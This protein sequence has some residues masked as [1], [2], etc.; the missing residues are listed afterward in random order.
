MDLTHLKVSLLAPDLAGGGGTRVYLLS[1]VL[2]QL[3]CQVQ[4]CGFSFGDRLYPEPPADL[5]VAWVRGCNYPQIWRSLR[6]LWPH[7]QGDVLYAV[8]PR[9][10]SFGVGLLKRWR[11]RRPLLLDIDDWEMSWF[12]G[13]TWRYRPGPKQLARDLLKPQGALRNPQHPVY[14]QWLEQRTGWADAI[15][16][17]NSFLQQRYGGTY[18]PNGKDTTL[19][20]PQAYDPEAC[21]ARYGLQGYRVLMFPGTARPHKGIEDLALALEQLQQP[22]FRIVLVGGR[23][24]G[25]GY[26]EGLLERWPQWLLRLP[27]QPMTAMPGV[28]AA[29]HAVIVP[30]RHDPTARAQ[31]PIKLTDGM[32]MAKPII[33][34][35]VGDIPQILGDTGY[36]VEPNQPG[37]I[38]QA[39]TEL[40]ADW[41]AAQRRG[42]AA[43]HRCVQY[44]SVNAMAIVLADLLAQVAAPKLP[45][46]SG[47]AA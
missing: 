1:Q 26:V 47:L 36:L 29:A 13:D 30:Q 5:S 21:R 7:L 46:T 15:T 42:Q 25:D 28:V 4:V 39:L 38:A 17:N 37:A 27:P 16:V 44:Y 23:D 14:L 31:F 34:T 43:R 12:G 35:R 22:D 32:A 9:P 6:Q 10:T 18:L 8:K 2:R 19:F 3:G 40:F 41:P 11:S 24:I 45:S 20:D 33:S